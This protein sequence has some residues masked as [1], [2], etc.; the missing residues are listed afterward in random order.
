MRLLLGGM[1]EGEDVED[2]QLAVISPGI[3]LDNPTALSVQQAGVPLLGELELAYQ[4][5]H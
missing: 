5:S 1:P 3:P 4:F 2:Y